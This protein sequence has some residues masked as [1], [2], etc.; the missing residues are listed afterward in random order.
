V[1]VKSGEF[2]SLAE[3]MTRKVSSENEVTHKVSLEL[4]Y[5]ILESDRK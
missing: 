4:V 5:S 2:T 1:S 3:K